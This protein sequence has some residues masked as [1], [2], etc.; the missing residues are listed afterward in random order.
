MAIF[1]VLWVVYLNKDMI[2]KWYFREDCVKTTH[3]SSI[4]ISIVLMSALIFKYIH[5]RK[6]T[7]RPKR[8]FVPSDNSS[9]IPKSDNSS[10][11]TIRPILKRRQFVPIIKSCCN[12]E[13][14]KITIRGR[15]QRFSII[16]PH[17]HFTPYH[18]TP[19]HFTPHSFHPR[20]ISPQVHFTPNSFHPKFISPHVHFTPHLNYRE[21]EIAS[22]EI[23]SSEISS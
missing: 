21:T 12:N 18:F 20:F 4:R 3:I 19:C 8:R 23:S 11:A 17:V 14:G 16:S 13:S 22:S 6:A 1:C 5:I 2:I 9:Q 15:C 7:I 10:Q